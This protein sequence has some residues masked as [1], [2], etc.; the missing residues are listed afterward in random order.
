MTTE[1]YSP[2]SRANAGQAG[3]LASWNHLGG[4]LWEVR[5]AAGDVT[6]AKTPMS[7][8]PHLVYFSPMAWT[9]ETLNQTVDAELTDCRRTCVRDCRISELIESV[10]LPNVKEPHVRHIRGS[11]GRF[12]SRGKL[13]SHGRYTS[14]R[15]S[16]AW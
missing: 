3:F 6:L 13:A 11:S 8:I 2:E 15:R 1:R 4:W 16:S 7:A 12:V 5:A 14:P 10:G 9:V